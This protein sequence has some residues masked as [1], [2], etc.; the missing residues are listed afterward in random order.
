MGFNSGLK[1][2]NVIFLSFK[3]NARVHDAKS[4]HGPHSPAQ[5]RQLQPKRLTKVAFAT[6]PFWAQNPDSQPNNQSLSLP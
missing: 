4:G 2:L 3:A 6:E 1:G 5:A